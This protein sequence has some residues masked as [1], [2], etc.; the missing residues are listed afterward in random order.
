M[1]ELKICTALTVATKV[2]MKQ[3][4]IL[5]TLSTVHLH[6]LWIINKLN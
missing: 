5:Y 1:L 2:Q 3:V 6:I 4:N